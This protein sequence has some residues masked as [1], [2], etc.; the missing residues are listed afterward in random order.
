MASLPRTARSARKAL[1][2]ASRP[3]PTLELLEESDGP[4]PLTPH[5]DHAASNDVSSS[6]DLTVP[7]DRGTEWTGVH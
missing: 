5:L 3:P 6:G 4:S 7:D 1:S 2:F